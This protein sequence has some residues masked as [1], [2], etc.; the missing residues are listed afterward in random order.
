MYIDFLIKVFEKNIE[1]DALVWEDK[2][3]NYQ[4]L[5]DHLY[6]WQERIKSEK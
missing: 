4:W 1:K 5:L 3:Y 6:Y 2:V